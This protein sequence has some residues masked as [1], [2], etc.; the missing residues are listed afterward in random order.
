M[1]NYKYT[2][3]C[4]FVADLPPKWRNPPKLPPPSVEQAAR[5]GPPGLSGQPVRVIQALAGIPRPGT[6]G[7]SGQPIRPGTMI[8][9]QERYL[10]NCT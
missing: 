2:D 10:A 3:F 7:W 4:R 8:P 5:P 9:A 1:L 6:P